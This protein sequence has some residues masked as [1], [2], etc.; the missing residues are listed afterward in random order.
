MR[1]AE[2]Q[3]S[4]HEALQA[5]L[6][7]SRAELWTA[8]PGIIVSYPAYCMSEPKRPCFE[9]AHVFFAQGCLVI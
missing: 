7:G 4:L 8:L 6:E 2:R 1:N 9:F 3:D 5:A